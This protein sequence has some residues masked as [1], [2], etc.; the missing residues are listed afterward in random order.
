MKKSRSEEEIEVSENETTRGLETGAIGRR[1]ARL[2]GI[3]A[4]AAILVLGACSSEDASIARVGGRGISQA[5]FDAFVKYRNVAD[6]E[7]QQRAALEEYVEREAL[8]AVIERQGLLDEQAVAVDLNEYRKEMLIS[9]YFE[10]FLRESVTDQAVQNYYNS[11]PDEFSEERVRVA[12]I[13]LRTRRDMDETE[14]QVKLTTAREAYSKILA[15]EDFGEVAERM[16]E[17]KVSAKK[18]GDL[19]RLKRGAVSQVFSD[20]VFSMQEGVVSEPFETPF[21]FH[22]ASVTEKPQRISRSFD[23]VKGDIR[24]TLRNQARDAEYARLTEGM[25]VEIP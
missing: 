25:E 6:D 18:G 3:G 8:A 2:V 23:S 1:A 7:R 4:L 19:G 12:H 5:E 16:S 13:L 24:Y 10:R 11:H 14:R 21:G 20:R 22:I 15:G 17:D 9:R